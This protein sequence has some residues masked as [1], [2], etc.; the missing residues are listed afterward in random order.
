MKRTQFR[1]GLC[2]VAA[3]LLLVATGE[4]GAEWIH[5]K[6]STVWDQ[7]GILFNFRLVQTR[8]EGT[9]YTWVIDCRSKRALALA[10]SAGGTTERYGGGWFAV[11][12]ATVGQ[13]VSDWAC[14]RR[15]E[16][17]PRD[18]WL[19]APAGEPY[20]ET[21]SRV[22]ELREFRLTWITLSR[23]TNTEIG[24]VN[25]GTRAARRIAS[26]APG[27]KDDLLDHR[28]TARPDVDLMGYPCGSYRW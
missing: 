8:V 18:R 5:L 24:V 20:H 26:V 1:V 15:Y 6:D 4:V 11:Q 25:C 23:Q 22:G 21:W 3:V 9:D 12:T 7:T 17:T 10:E 28:W 27:D 19:A 13:Q 2:L 14:E 16:K